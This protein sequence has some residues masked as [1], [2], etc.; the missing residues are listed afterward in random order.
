[1]KKAYLLAPL[2]LLSCTDLDWRPIVVDEH[3]TVQLPE[4]PKQVDA[5]QLQSRGLKLAMQVVGE[6]GV[7]T[8]LSKAPNFSLKPM[9][10]ARR[11]SFYN[12]GL[13]DALASRRAGVLLANSSF[14][15]PAGDGR[16]FVIRGSSALAPRRMTYFMR[17][18]LIDRVAYSF[19]F[20]ALDQE[21]STKNK[22]ARRFLNSITVKP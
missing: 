11:D 9:T 21:D 8:V 14:S 16:E 13:R 5:A 17:V 6:Q 15:T 2:F 22:D 7:Y 4:Q 20:G 19:G 12:Q 3:I 10:Q 18:L 1:M